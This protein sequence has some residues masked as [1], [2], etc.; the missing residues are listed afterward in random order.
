MALATKLKA[1]K[2]RVSS[3]SLFEL[4]NC[5]EKKRGINKNKFLAQ[6]FIRKSLNKSIFK[7]QNTQ[8]LFQVQALMKQ[9]SYYILV[10]TL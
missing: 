6:S 1:K 10:I 9:Q 5:P 8:I 4:N 2:P 7:L 3:V